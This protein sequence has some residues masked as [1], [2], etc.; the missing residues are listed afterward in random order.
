M[1]SQGNDYQ[2]LLDYLA[3]R[4]HSPQEIR[5]I[6]AHVEDYDEKTQHDS[7]MDSIGSGGIDLE[8]LVREALSE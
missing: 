6:M 7:I 1:E 8:A 2:V 3:E 5:T 4:G